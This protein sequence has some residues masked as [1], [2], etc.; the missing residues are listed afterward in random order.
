MK[1]LR[2][3]IWHALLL[4]ILL[5][6]LNHF[7]NSNPSI[8]QGELAGIPTSTW[9][10]LALAAPIAHQ[11]YVLVCWRAELYYKALSKSLGSNAFKLFKLGFVLLILSRLFTICFLAF[12][13]AKSL[14]LNAKL[15]YIL[16]AALAMLS[17][18]LFYSVKKYFGADRAM[19]IDHFEPEKFRNTELIKQGIFKYTSNGMYVYGML[20]LWIPGFLLQSKAALAI[21][22]FNHLYIWVHYFFTELPDM[23]EIYGEKN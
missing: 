5:F 20:L 12:S 16:A 11:L 1:I 4:S 22:L 9:F 3:Q 17:A 15:S 14:E 8:L 7:T 23:K 2:R 18:Y 19:G 21:A 13:N 10:F 6:L